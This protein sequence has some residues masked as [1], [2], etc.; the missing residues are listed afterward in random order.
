MEPFLQII[1]LLNTKCYVSLPD[2]FIGRNLSLNQLGW[3]GA[4]EYGN[5]QVFVEKR[6]GQLIAGAH[7]FDFFVCFYIQFG[8]LSW[9]AICKYTVPP[10]LDCIYKSTYF[11]LPH[12]CQIL[13]DL[14]FRSICQNS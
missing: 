5:L 6:S 12:S 3:I 13:Q 8:L 9:K 7:P 1:L 11:S 10:Y 2:L 14:F 4:G